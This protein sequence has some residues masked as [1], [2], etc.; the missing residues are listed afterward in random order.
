M[1]RRVMWKLINGY[2]DEHEPSAERWTWAKMLEVAGGYGKSYDPSRSLSA[3]W[4]YDSG[5]ADMSYYASPQY[6]YNNAFSALLPSRQTYRLIAEHESGEVCDVGGTFFSAMTLIENGVESVI[7]ENMAG[8]QTEFI[9]WMAH[10]AITVGP[11]RPGCVLAAV[12]YLEHFRDV[13]A[14]FDRLLACGP[15]VLYVATSFC[16]PCYGHFIPV[17]IGNSEYHE[18]VAA[19]RA[20]RTHARDR[21]FRL[22]RVDGYNSKLWVTHGIL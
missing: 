22:S 2:L 5:Q 16:K 17:R 9:K 1:E 13:S 3:K 7:V 6:L 21:G 19:T 12:E 14:E 10:P 11:P 15:S 18:H 4:W 20:F 8:H